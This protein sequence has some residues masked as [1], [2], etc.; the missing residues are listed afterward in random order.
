M[1]VSNEKAFRSCERVTV[2]TL[3]ENADW[4][5]LGQDNR[6]APKFQFVSTLPSRY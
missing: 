6:G 1:P 5:L 2:T 4:I 3:A